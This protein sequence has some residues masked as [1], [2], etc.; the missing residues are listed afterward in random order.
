MIIEPMTKGIYTEETLFKF[1]KR[2]PYEKFYFRHLGLNNMET[3]DF[4]VDKLHRRINNASNKNNSLW[5]VKDHQDIRGIFGVHRNQLHSEIF[6][7]N[8]FELGP[9]YNFDNGNSKQVFNLF[10]DKLKLFLEIYDNIFLKCKI[11]SSD[12]KNITYFNSVGFKYYA[13]GQKVLYNHKIGYPKFVEYYYNKSIQKELFFEVA[14]LNKDKDM[15]AV[16]SLID[17]HEKSEHFY[18][19]NDDFDIKKTNSLFKIWFTK[20]ISD[21]KTKVYKLTEK[22]SERIVG[23]TSFRGPVDIAGRNIY[24]RDLT[25]LEKSFRGQ[26]LASLLYNKTIHDTKTFIEGNPMADNYQNLKLNQKCG[27]NM[28]QTRSYFKMKYEKTP[29][30]KNKAF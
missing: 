11:D 9:I 21:S 6:N 22:Q 7:C 27:F 25:V 10:W 29:P 13:T 2:Y 28:V 12:H 8:I 1:F 3:I 14:T 17:Q 20:Y 5:V 4:L 23:F 15:E 19:Y 16:F 30:T 24:T 18:N 26:G